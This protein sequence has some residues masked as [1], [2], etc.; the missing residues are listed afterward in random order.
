MMESRTRSILKGVSWRVIGTFDTMVLSYLISGVLNHAIKIGITEVITKVGLYYLHE[1]IWLKALAG[2]TQEQWVSVTKAVTWRI[3][4]TA[5]TILWGAFFTGDPWKG[6][7]IGFAE[8]FTKIILYYLH[9]RAWNRVPV[10][11]VRKA[12]YDED[13]IAEPEVVAEKVEETEEVK[14]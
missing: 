5:D 11:T 12:L 13:V 2:R 3:V 8:L 10:G 14:S 1:R 9:E 7:K 6:F 4:G